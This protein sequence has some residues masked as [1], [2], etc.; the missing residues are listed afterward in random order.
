M[1]II[2]WKVNGMKREKKKGK[3]TKYFTG[4]YG[5]AL[6]VPEVLWT[7]V[8]F[9]KRANE[10]CVCVPYKT[11]LLRTGQLNCMR[12]VLMQLNKR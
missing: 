10:N 6:Y 12:L 8:A 3:K 7:R 5:S 2:S 1:G 9:C 4:V 11:Y